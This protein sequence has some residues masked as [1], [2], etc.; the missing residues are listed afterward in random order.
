MSTPLAPSLLRGGVL[1]WCTGSSSSLSKNCCCK[2]FIGASSSLRETLSVRLSA[3]SKQPLRIASAMLGSGV[4]S[5]SVG[6]LVDV[7]LSFSEKQFRMHASISV[8][9]SFE[10]E[11]LLPSRIAGDKLGR[12]DESLSARILV[13]VCFPSRAQHS[14]IYRSSPE[15]IGETTPLPLPLLR[16]KQLSPCNESS[17]PSLSNGLLLAGARTCCCNSDFCFPSGL[18]SHSCSC[19]LHFDPSIPSQ[20]SSKLS[21]SSSPTPSAL[22][23][24]ICRKR[25]RINRSA[26]SLC[27]KT[28][29]ARIED[30][31]LHRYVS[32]HLYVFLGLLSYT[33]LADADDEACDRESSNS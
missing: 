7:R 23:D 24:G 21:I 8:L 2:P 1:S 28:E 9:S 20:T 31:T 32:F 12:G 13:E 30:A 27:K 16:G 19:K 18:T 29:V 26:A 11:S 6:I 17:S 33:Y 25:C 3:A 5:L 10:S 22:G 15:L 14:R 4:D